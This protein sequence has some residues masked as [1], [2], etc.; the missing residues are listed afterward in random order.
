[1]SRTVTNGKDTT[2]SDLQAQIAALKTD[3]SQLS[4]TIVDL[5]KAQTDSL[6]ATTKDNAAALKT[7][8]EVALDQARDT[9]S[10]LVSDAETKVRDNPGTAV[11]IATG[12]GF[13]LGMAAG[14]R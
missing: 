7:K 4:T 10:T 9:A 6:A 1:M 8:G 12:L 13:L 3:I 2:I 11:A 5:G 14:R